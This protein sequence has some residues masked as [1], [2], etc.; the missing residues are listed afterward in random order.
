[1]SPAATAR[2]V[3]GRAVRIVI[4]V[5]VVVML[6]GGAVSSVQARHATRWRSHDIMGAP[7]RITNGMSGNLGPMRYY[8]GPKSPMWR[9]PV[10][11]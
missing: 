10:Q 3:S 6:T 5:A 2:P 11:N 9:G 1:M 4:A 7:Q 8:G